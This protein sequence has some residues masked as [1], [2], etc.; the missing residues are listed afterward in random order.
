MSTGTVKFFNQKNGFGFIIEEGTNKEIF[1]RASGLLESIDQND[2]V[3]FTIKEGAKGPMA[4]DVKK[5][6]S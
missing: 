6:K 3:T 2:K 1:V 4:V 5:I